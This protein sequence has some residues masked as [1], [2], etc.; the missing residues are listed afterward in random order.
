V[1]GIVRRLLSNAVVAADALLVKADFLSHPVNMATRL[2][3]VPRPEG[4]PSWDRSRKTDA[5]RLR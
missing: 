5:L 2:H 3:A 1:A 4:E